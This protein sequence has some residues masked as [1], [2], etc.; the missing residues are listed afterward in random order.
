M[1]PEGSCP[2]DGSWT[3]E[4]CSI[5]QGQLAKGVLSSCLYREG[6]T[7]LKEVIVRNPN[8]STL[9]IK[10]ILVDGIPDVL[11]DTCL[12]KSAYQ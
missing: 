8:I 12:L 6:C 10:A 4:C 3:Q 11:K 9:V 2:L 7:E 1:S 5:Y